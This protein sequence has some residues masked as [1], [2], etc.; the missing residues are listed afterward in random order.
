MMADFGFRL[1]SGNP[2]LSFGKGWAGASTFKTIFMKKIKI[3]STLLLIFNS[4]LFFSQNEF[5]KWYFG[6]FAGLDFSTSPPTIL[7]NGVTSSNGGATICDNTGNLLFYSNGG[8]AI[9]NNTH[10]VMANGNGLAGIAGTQP[11]VAVKQPGNNTL[12]YVFTLDQGGGING[13]KYS[14]VDMALAAGLGSVTIKNA[15]LYT[16]SCEKQVAVR[17]CNGRD[18]WIVSHEYNSNKFRSYLLTSIGLNPTPVI[19]AIGET[20]GQGNSNNSLMSTAGDMKITPDG[21]KLAL[22]V[23]GASVPSTLGLGGFQLFDFD[24]STGVISNSLIL[25]N[26]PNAIGSPFSV[27]FSS[28]GTKLYGVGQPSLNNIPA[29]L[30]QWDICSQ[31]TTAIIASQ[32]S[33]NLGAGF[34][35]GALQRAI[36]NKIYMA[37]G[38]TQNLHVINNPNA[39]GVAMGFTLNGQSLAPTST[40]YSGLPNYI[41]YYVKPN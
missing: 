40:C 22:A 39:S 28:D 24:A 25:L 41:N 4:S 36:N 17:H 8:N 21:K 12:Y 14:I 34:V 5:S 3:I 2:A 10:S 19:T 20:P 16:P 37:V 38:G 13:A 27:E 7:T 18:V 35:F 31:F 11:L 1:I 32:Y 9:F 15:T 33:L 30:Y 23:Y 29:I 6:Q 26:A